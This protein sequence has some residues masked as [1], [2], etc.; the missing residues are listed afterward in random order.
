[1][2]IYQSSIHPPHFKVLVDKDVID[3]P[4]VGTRRGA[5]LDLPQLSFSILQGYNNL[6]HAI[7]VFL[8]QV[9]THNSAMLG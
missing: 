8:H 7:I 1:M 3:I 5:V 4:K 9:K 2:F 6:F